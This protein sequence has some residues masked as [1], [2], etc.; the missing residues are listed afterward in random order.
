MNNQKELRIIVAGEDKN[1]IS[2]VVAIINR[3][4]ELYLAEPFV[5]IH[6]V[7]LE[8]A[9]AKMQKVI[10]SMKEDEVSF[11]ISSHLISK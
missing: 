7:D 9:E 4:L 5:E 1:E 8:K 3:A 10:K 6:G 11:S 2:S